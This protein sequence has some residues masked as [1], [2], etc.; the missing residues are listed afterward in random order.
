MDG[1]LPMCDCADI[2]TQHRALSSLSNSTGL[3]S[4]QRLDQKLCSFYRRVISRGERESCRGDERT[5]ID[6]APLVSID[7]DSRTRTEYVPRPT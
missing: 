3:R 5:S 7:G 6:G 1:N 4:I 2:L